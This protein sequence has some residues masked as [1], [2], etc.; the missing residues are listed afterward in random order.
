M[1]KYTNGKI[2]KIEDL[3]GD[4]CYIG[5]TTETLLSQRM[6]GHRGG[7]KRWKEEKPTTRFTVFD[8]FDT[9]GVENCRII[10]LE[11]YPCNTKDEL[12]S[13]EAHYI[14]TEKCVNK[15]IP[16]RKRIEYRATHKKEGAEYAK[17]YY[18]KNKEK[19]DITAKKYIAENLEAINARRKSVVD[20]ICGGHYVRSNKSLHYI[21][22]K[23]LA[24]INE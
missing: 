10:L 7:Y 6:A 4:M 13:R 24:N 12:L 18:I 8:I 20:C 2:Y 19:V 1:T 11:L 5:S 23:H 15:V 14:R 17:L 21:S 9:Y 3:N 22:K 16:D